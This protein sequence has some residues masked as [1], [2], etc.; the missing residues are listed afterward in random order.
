MCIPK[1][2]RFDHSIVFFSQTLYFV[3]TLFIY[4][5]SKNS[6]FPEHTTKFPYGEISIRR[7]CFYGEISIRRNIRTTKIPAAKFP[8]G[9]IS[10]R[11]SFLWR[12]FPRRNFLPRNFLAPFSTCLSDRPLEHRFFFPN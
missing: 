1:S 10:L 9:E 6:N 3:V 5:M 4:P 8:Y 11:R 12:K 7:T 2:R